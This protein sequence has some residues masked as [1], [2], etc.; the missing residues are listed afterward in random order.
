MSENS[1]PNWHGTTILCLRKAV[2]VIV[3]GDCQASMCDTVVKSN[4][5]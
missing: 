4:S 5:V 1:G 3:A 2:E